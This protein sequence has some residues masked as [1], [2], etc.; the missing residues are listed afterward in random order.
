MNDSMRKVLLYILGAMVLFLSCV[1]RNGVVVPTETHL[2]EFTSTKVEGG[3]RTYKVFLNGIPGTTTANHPEYSGTYYGESGVLQPCS[4]DNNGVFIEEDSSKGLRAAN[5]PYKM[6]I[7][8]PA[9]DKTTFG[10]TTLSGYMYDR[11]QDGVY[12][13]KLSDVEVSGVYME[14]PHGDDCV[15]DAQSDK[16]VQQRSQLKIIFAC[17]QDISSTTLYSINLKN[18]ID[19]GYYIPAEAR[20]Y[21]E[22]IDI[23]NEPLYSGDPKLLNKGEEY[24]LKVNQY[25]LS[26]DYSE[27]ADGGNYRWPLPSLEIKIG[28][29]GGKTFTADMGFA[30]EPQHT[31]VIKIVINSNFLGLTV[32]VSDWDNGGGGS[33]SVDGVRSWTFNVPIK[34]GDNN[35]VLEWDGDGNIISG[36]IV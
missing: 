24:D 30:F 31:Y 22:D 3:G 7:V 12:I 19:K 36:E 29:S 15:Y 17:G 26:M 10:E 14:D 27:R 1:G 2:V 8:S 33:S 5:G 11:N 16:L 32:D 20:F 4:V 23:A 21:Y 13:S 35:M 6:Y 28:E 18:I 34:D 25:I 9:I